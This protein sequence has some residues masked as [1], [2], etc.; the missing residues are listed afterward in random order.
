MKKTIL[1]LGV[2][3]AST[4]ASHA[5]V[6]LGDLAV[7]GYNADNPDRFWIMA[8]NEIAAGETFLF[9]DNGW[10]SSQS[11]RTGE[12]RKTYTVGATITVGSIVQI[13]VS[14]GTG[15]APALSTG[16]DQLLIFTGTS[17]DPTF[18]YGV[19]NEGTGVWQANATN[20]NTSALPTGLTNG[21][22]AVALNE[23]DNATF[24]FGT[25]GSDKTAAEW[26]I[27]IGNKN[28]WISDDSTLLEP[29]VTSAVVTPIP[30]PSSAALLGLAVLALVFRRHK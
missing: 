24:N 16:G 26:L 14:E 20:S 23:K 12:G 4:V 6:M 11:F 2:I 17:A 10:S 18:L 25:H 13:G 5:A 28:N 21:T 29:T 9:T 15:T 8:L 1:T 7:V 3:A 30:E 27:A 22:T 19:N